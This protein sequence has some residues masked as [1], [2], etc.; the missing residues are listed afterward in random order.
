MV[1]LKH[2]YT[3][4]D[5]DLHLLQTYRNLYT[6]RKFA[7]VTLVSDDHVKFLAHKTVLAAASPVLKSLL[8]LNL[9]EGH[10]I[11]FLKGVHSEELQS[12]LEYIYLGQAS[13]SLSNIQG[14]TSVSKELGIHDNT[15]MEDVVKVPSEERKLSKVEKTKVEK[16]DFLSDMFDGQN[17]S[18]IDSNKVTL[19]ELEDQTEVFETPDEESEDIENEFPTADSE[20][21]TLEESQ[22]ETKEVTSVDNDTNQPDQENQRKSRKSKV[23]R[24]KEDPAYCDICNVH[25][26]T[27][28]SYARHVKTI[29]ELSKLTKCDLCDKVCKSQDLLRQHKRTHLEKT[30]PCPECDWKTTNIN[31]LMRHRLKRHA[32]VCEFHNV[33]FRTTEEMEKHLKEEHFDKYC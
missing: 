32:K 11:L 1:V 3:L 5:F 28:R 13:V 21:K 10:Q 6:D 24:K 20:E 22:S 2:N 9:S 31:F 7:D 4:Q 27:K 30:I 29:H 19:M 14:F 23:I 33:R 8:M 12:L 18:S 26:T 25:F 17:E 16:L 15:F